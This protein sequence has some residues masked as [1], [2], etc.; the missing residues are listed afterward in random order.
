MIY[1]FRHRGLKR[2]FE[3]GDPSRI[4]PNQV[5]KIRSI[6]ADLNAALT[7]E[8]MRQSGYRLHEL[9]GNLKGSY[10]VDVSG[11]WRIMFSYE[12][13]NAFDVDLVDYH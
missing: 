1:N 2:F 9:K 3:Q 8:H 4:N 6:L 5:K 7:V 12:C 13:G 11:N 10:A